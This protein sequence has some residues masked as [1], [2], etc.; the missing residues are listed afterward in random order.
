MGL[1]VLLVSLIIFFLL[2]VPIAFALIIST[3]LYFLFNDDFS[4]MVIIQR[5]VGG[6]ESVPLLAIIFFITAGILM[7]YTGITSR[8]LRF[9]EVIT[10]PLPGALAQVNVV[11]ST[12]MG[13]LSG[14]N[15]ADAAM[16][17]K[18]LVPEM[19]KKGYDKGFATALTAATSLITPIIP[20]GIALIMYGYIGNVSIGKLFMAGVV[21]GIALC[22]MMM[23][24]VHIYA[25]KHKL[26]VGDKKKVTWK[27][28]FLTGK[29]AILA[30]LLPVIIIG[31]IRLGFFSATEAGAIAVLYA[32]ILGLLI[33]REM[34]IKQMIG[35]LVETVHT[36]ASILII[37]A[38]GSAFAW[39]LSLEQV[40]QRMT[41]FMTG[42]ISSPMLFFIIVMIFL[43]LI[44]MFIEG[45]VALVILTPLFMPMLFE[46]GI[47]PVHFGI[48]FIVC[49]SIGT[50]TPPLGTIMFVTCSITGTKI[51]EFI[52]HSIPFL[53]LLIIAALII[54]FIPAISLFL[55]NLLF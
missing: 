9:A 1:V 12:L 42:F 17:A 32:L 29:D 44:G 39:V 18:V 30:L 14:S 6:L 28:F 19:E 20:P 43:L 41:E 3:A 7:N 37:I 52:K 5:M 2:N 54:A 15:I 21:P 46:Y 27:E 10:R 13:G 8:M 22:I 38:A 34:S 33:Y 50:L 40:P 51:E 23:I 35:A 49:L 16:Q 26:E 31:G 48:F 25:K 11:L 53:I 55:P 36:S 4:S 45:N 47:D 24:Y